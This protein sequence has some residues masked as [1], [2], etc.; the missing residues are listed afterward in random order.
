VQGLQLLVLRLPGDLPP[1][2]YHLTAQVV[3]RRSGQTLPAATGE[4]VITLG[5]LAGQL[6][7][8]TSALLGEGPG[9]ELALRGYD[10]KNS[11]VQP[12][13]TLAVTLHWQVLQPPREDYALEFF[14]VDDQMKRV[15]RW[16]ALEPINGEWPTHHRLDLVVG[17][18]APRGQFTLRVAWVSE[19]GESSQPAN[20]GESSA[21]FELERVTIT[22]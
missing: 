1:R 8:P 6:A 13:A 4:T 10:L 11:A 22:D 18:D 17:D 16:P 20:P 9:Q 7:H 14:L 5:A 19:T 2:T 3:D 21:S 15:Y 12:G